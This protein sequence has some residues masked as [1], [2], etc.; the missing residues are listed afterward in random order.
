[1]KYGFTI[2][3]DQGA[4]DLIK[5]NTCLIALSEPIQALK[6]LLRG[7]LIENVAIL[8]GDGESLLEAATSKLNS[9]PQMDFYTF[10]VS[11]LIITVA[12]VTISSALGI[13][14]SIL[15]Q[16]SWNIADVPCNRPNGKV[17]S[18]STWPALAGLAIW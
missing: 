12:G 13:V 10:S 8:V 17:L 15:D 7:K 9:C 1:M 6:P 18:A 3:E 4:F 11:H 2:V 5:P 14:G 16:N